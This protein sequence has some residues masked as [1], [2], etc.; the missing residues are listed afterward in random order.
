MIPLVNPALA[1]QHAPAASQPWLAGP[2]RWI[3]VALALVASVDAAYLTWTSLTHGI[4][5]GCNGAETAGCDDVLNSHWSRAAGLPVALG[6]LACYA[7]IFGL[8][9]AAGSRWFNANRWI[10]TALATAAILA[11][12]SGLWFTLLQVFA[13]H[14]FCYYCLGIHLC[15]LAIAALVV[16]SMLSKP[17]RQ[18]GASRSHATLA[19]IPGSAGPRRSIGPRPAEGPSLVA[20]G[21]IAAGMLGLLIA[22]QILFPP[23]S[24]EVSQPELTET[25]DMTAS[26]DTSSTA[27]QE[28]SPD[29]LSHTVNRVTD[30]VADGDDPS[31]KSVADPAVEHQPPVSAVAV[32]AEAAPALSREVTFLNGRIKINI[33]DEAVLGSP[34]A[35]YVV[36]EMMDYTCPH[37][38]KMYAQIEDALDRFGDQLAVVIM[39]VPLE[40]ECNKLVPSTDPLHRGACKIAELSLGVAKADPIRFADF[41]DF[42]MADPEKSPTSAQAVVRAFRLTDRTK[43]REVTQDT[44][45]AARIQKYI[46]LFSTLS[47]QNKAKIDNFGLPVQIVGDTVLAGDMTSEEMLAA[48]NKALG[49]EPE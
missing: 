14:T 28:L 9:L 23:K 39:P 8:S 21:P 16:W 49:I 31:E 11:A 3:V 36:V 46:S 44:A 2:I 25:I 6:G 38:R 13:L 41:H 48:W 26:A 32:A 42:L 5:I 4:V 34:D 10:G 15:G 20:A 30:A 24:F 19:A 29:A 40:L 45:I 33:Y 18:V 47:A 43:L 17:Q 37:C 1:R 22:G 7:A 27:A 12:A 35:K